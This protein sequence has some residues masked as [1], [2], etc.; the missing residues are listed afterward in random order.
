MA[1]DYETLAAD[2]RGE[3]AR[4]LMFIGEN[5]DLAGELPEPRMVRQSDSAG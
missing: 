2:H 5:P 3:V 1:M 4:A